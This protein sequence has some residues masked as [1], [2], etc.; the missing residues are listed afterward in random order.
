MSD[1]RPMR[2]DYDSDPDRFR[3]ARQVTLEFG[4]VGDAHGPVV[5][6]LARERLS[7]VLDVGCGDGALGRPL[8]Q[9][10][11]EWVGLDLSPTLLADAPRPVVRAQATALPF[12]EA[13]F[14]AVAAVFMLYHLADPCH[15]IAEAYRVLRPGGL[16]VAVAPSR[17]DSPELHHLMPPEPPSTF[18]AELAPD[19]LGRYFADVETDAWDGPYITLPDVEALRRYLIGRGVPR[20]TAAERAPTMQFPI[21]LTKR[22]SISYARK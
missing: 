11:L 5:L 7:P 22:G 12:Q 14:G 17:F 15:A 3:T 9:T 6:R 19:L 2:L 16:F 1:A 4:P 13:S 10:G 18:D 8:L 20:A 21:A